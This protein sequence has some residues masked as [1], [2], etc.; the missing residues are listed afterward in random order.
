MAN[1]D[2]TPCVLLDDGGHCL[3]Y[4]H[5]PMTCRL[6]GI[7]LIDINGEI[8][9]DATCTLNFAE[10]DPFALSGLSFEFEQ[11]FRD[12]LTFFQLFTK[13]L[14]KQRVSEL[15]VLIPTALLFDYGSFDWQAWLKT[16]D[17]RQS[18]KKGHSSVS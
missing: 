16:P 18:L 10:K 5:R 14:L 7:P 11:L 4:D 2:E 3:V 8:F 17:A 6:H 13:H 15:D 9:D 1:D 12:E